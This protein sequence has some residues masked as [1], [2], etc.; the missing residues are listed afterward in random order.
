MMHLRCLG[1]HAVIK[2][3]HFFCF[4]I[5]FPAL[6]LADVPETIKVPEVNTLQMTLFAKG[7]QIYQCLFADG[8]YQWQWQAPDAKLYEPQNQS[9]VGSHGAGPS[10]VYK[11]GSSLKAKALQKVNSPEKSAAPWLLLEV[12]E[13]KGDGMLTNT[14]YI[15]RIN[16]TGGISPSSA[17]DGNHLGAEKRVSYTA[18]YVFYMK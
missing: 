8:A 2:K 14:R 18:D 5:I 12:T 10:W 13:H 7:D 15:Q 3:L 6:V 11:D 1:R 16:T 17:C 4:F 9:Q